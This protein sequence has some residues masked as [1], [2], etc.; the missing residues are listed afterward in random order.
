MKNSFSGCFGKT[1][2]EK[3]TWR[4]LCLVKLIACSFTKMFPTMDNFVGVFKKFSE[5]PFN[6]QINSGRLSLSKHN[7]TL[8]HQIWYNL[9]VIFKLTWVLEH[10]SWQNV[11]L[12]ILLKRFP[13][14]IQLYILHLQ[15]T[16]LNLPR[17]YFSSQNE[18]KIIMSNFAHSFLAEFFLTI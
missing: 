8:K 13:C 10:F 14:V 2:G 6:R 16:I 5:Q 4:G 9:G 18:R 3:N 7:F 17:I 1:H 12:D 15:F 11:G